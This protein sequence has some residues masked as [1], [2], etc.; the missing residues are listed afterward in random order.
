MRRI[1]F[2]AVLMA[3]IFG[4]HQ[5]EAQTQ[6]QAQ[7]V[8]NLSHNIGNAPVSPFFTQATGSDGTVY[9]FAPAGGLEGSIVSGASNT[10]TVSGTLTIVGSSNAI[11]NFNDGNRLPRGITLTYDLSFT[12]STNDGLLVTANGN[13]GNGLGPGQLLSLIHI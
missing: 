5:L 3:I 6:Q 2:G 10:T 13:T 1:F 11:T 9:N 8:T 4:A 12:V 7:V